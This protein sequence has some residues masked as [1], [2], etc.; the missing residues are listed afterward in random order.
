MDLYANLWALVNQIDGFGYWGY[1][2]ISKIS[3]RLQ[4]SKMVSPQW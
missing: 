4:I 1:L 3:P 2:K